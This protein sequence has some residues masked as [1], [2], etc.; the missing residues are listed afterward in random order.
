MPS[1]WHGFMLVVAAIHLLAVSLPAGEI[2]RWRDA[3]GVV[4]FSDSPPAMPADEV[5]SSLVP[6]QNPEP[7]VKPPEDSARPLSGGVFWRIEPP[8]RPPSFLLG[9]IHSADPRVTAL[10]P[11]VSQAFDRAAIF[12]ME[13]DLNAASFLE[14]G[15]SMMFTDNR[16]LEELLGR[17]EFRKVAAAVS[18]H[19]IPE[20]I[21]RKMKP[22]AVM[23]LLSQPTPQKGAF[24]DMMLYQ[25]ATAAGKPVYGLESAAEQIA[26]FSRMPMTDQ[27][28]MLR[29]SL[30]QVNQMPAM[31]D[32]MIETYLAG[33]LD[34]IAG[35]TEE[36]VDQDSSGLSR[37]FIYQLNDG[38][39]D[40][41]VTRMTPH[42]DAGGAFVA[43]GALHLTGDRGLVRQ[44][45]A[46]GYRLSPVD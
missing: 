41:M 25:R 13:M 22:W 7:M 38:R 2:Y 39:N 4:H 6:A 43:V 8:G 34:A 19:P 36:L 26:V 16:D 5:R 3:D 10:K 18:A 32:R 12:V 33:D 15:A 37:R 14:L 9:T 30:D 35:L 29:T 46:R 23:A 17:D 1:I 31:Q 45:R 42:I 27:L 21:L 40:R 44:L 28:A 24:M 20:P 11:S